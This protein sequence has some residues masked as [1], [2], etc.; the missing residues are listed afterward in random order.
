MNN[1]WE[2]HAF[3]HGGCILVQAYI[4]SKAKPHN[5]IRGVTMLRA[6]RPEIIRLNGALK[7]NKFDT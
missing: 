5:R 6:D 2:Y 4:H 1:P 3:T 7:T